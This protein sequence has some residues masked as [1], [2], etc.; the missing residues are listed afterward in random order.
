MEIWGYGWT[1][2]ARI[3]KARLFLSLQANR[4]TGSTTRAGSSSAM[5]RADIPR[6]AMAK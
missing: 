3:S 4:Q 2:S 5:A 6:M 1:A